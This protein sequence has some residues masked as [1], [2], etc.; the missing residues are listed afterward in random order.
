MVIDEF[1]DLLAC[2]GCRSELRLEAGRLRC[3]SDG[4]GG[5]F[6]VVDGRPVLIWEPRSVFD[7]AAFREPRNLLRRS[8]FAIWAQGWLPGLEHNLTRQANYERFR[9]MVKEAA[10]LPR[11]L[12][13]EIFRRCDGL[14]Q[15]RS[16]PGLWLLTQNLTFGDHVDLIADGHDLPF[17]DASFDAVTAHAV[18][19]HFADPDRV[20]AEVHR[21]L[22]PRG[23]AYAEAP[24]LQPVHLGRHDY[25]RFTPL[26]A[27]RL[28]RRFE[29]VDH[30]V[31]NGPGMVLGIAYASFLEA[32]FE[33]PILR[34]AA[35]LFARLTGF[36]LKWWD[37][38]LVRRPAGWDSIAG[39]WFLLRRS[40]SVATDREITH[41]YEGSQRDH[42]FGRP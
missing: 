19:D 28:L 42:V 14:E 3:T 13:I 25:L 34:R 9:R 10:P 12:N 2:P 37:R 29:V 6:P 1:L 8:R 22:K 35:F 39:T 40:D 15:L 26:G 38:L 5:T 24:F 18:L 17:R 21:V 31:A 36:W 11:V 27:R 33:T 4:C 16:D 32:F 7:V 20:M 30:G 23:L 41:H